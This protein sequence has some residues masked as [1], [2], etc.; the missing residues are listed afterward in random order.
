MTDATKTRISA[1]SK[2]I[3]LIF[4]IIKIYKLTFLLFPLSFIISKDDTFQAQF[5][6]LTITKNDA[7][8]AQLKSPI[9]FP[10]KK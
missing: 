3:H 1:I 2:G 6:R 10:G 5:K 9:W 7:L 4:G 8:Q